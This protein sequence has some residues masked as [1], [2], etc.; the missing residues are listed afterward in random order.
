MENKT[1]PSH[2]CMEAAILSVVVT[3][4]FICR[5]TPPP[6]IPRALLH[7]LKEEKNMQSVFNGSMFKKWLK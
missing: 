6:P 3:C 4:S 7:L 2:M 5:G 1:V